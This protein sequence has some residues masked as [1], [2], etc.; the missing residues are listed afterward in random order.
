MPLEMIYES[1]QPKAKVW[2][3]EERCPWMI[4]RL[5]QWGTLVEGSREYH[6][7]VIAHLRDGGE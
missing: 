2:N 4:Y 3:R 6:Q 7:G 5:I 1:K